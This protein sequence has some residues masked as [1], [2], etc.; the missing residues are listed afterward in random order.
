VRLYG[1]AADIELEVFCREQW[2][3]LVGSLQLYVGDREL[4]EELAQETLV[5][6]VQH[7]EDVAQADSPSAWAHRVAFNLAKSQFRRRLAQRRARSRAGVIALPEPD[8]A[9][10]VAVRA[11]VAGLPEA[12]RSALVLRYFADLPLRQVATVMNCPENT[13]KSHIRRAIEALR[14]AGLGNPVESTS[15]TSGELR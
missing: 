3:R 7:W 13:V 5:R 12:Q 8:L 2:G 15:S 4:A 6:A 14:G 9:S 1:V 10:A 11:A